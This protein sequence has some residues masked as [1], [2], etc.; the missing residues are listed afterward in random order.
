[1]DAPGCDRGTD[2]DDQ[3]ELLDDGLEIITRLWRG[4]WSFEGTWWIEANW[5]AMTSNHLDARARAGPPQPDL[6]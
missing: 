1:V 5:A 4:D 2:A 6:A 3:A